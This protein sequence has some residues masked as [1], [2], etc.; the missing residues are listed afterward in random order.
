MHATT[1][2]TEAERQGNALSLATLTLDWTFLFWQTM[3]FAAIVLT[4]NLAVGVVL[5]FAIMVIWKR[6]SDWR[7]AVVALFILACVLASSRRPG[8]QHWKMLRCSMLASSSLRNAKQFRGMPIS[9]RR[10]SV[11]LL[12]VVLFATGLRCFSDMCWRGWRRRCFCLRC[13]GPWLCWA[14]Q[15]P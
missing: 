10:G 9:E 4:Q 7:E 2:S 6:W 1:Q 5:S 14:G 3:L 12:L 13:G 15:S 11:G 8:L